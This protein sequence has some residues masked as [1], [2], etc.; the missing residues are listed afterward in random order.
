[1]SNRDISYIKVA[2][3]IADRSKALN[4]KIGAVIVSKDNQIISTGWNG[5]P[6]GIDEQNFMDLFN[7]KTI[8]SILHGYIYQVIVPVFGGA[9]DEDSGNILYDMFIEYYNNEFGD[10]LL[11]GDFPVP[12]QQ[13]HPYYVAKSLIGNGNFDDFLVDK[14]QLLQS[15]EKEG[16]K[17]PRYYHD[18]SGQLASGNKL[19]MQF[20]VH[21][22]V[23]AVI[24]AGRERC[25]DSTLYLTCGI[26]CK[27]CM[28][29]IINSGIRRIVCGVDS[30]EIY[31]CEYNF[32]AS[33]ILARKA[34][35]KIDF[36][37]TTKKLF[38]RQ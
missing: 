8:E 21:A 12:V 37:G 5:L 3:A 25:I 32:E 23:N 19:W 22:E 30:P 11:V 6:R 2:E 35:I 10:T 17:D 20:D 26:P 14:E 18:F 27:N 1:M 7:D 13:L 33:K 29:V 16:I 4:K 15:I 38:E 31:P 28:L 9:I 36:I 24:N 34:D